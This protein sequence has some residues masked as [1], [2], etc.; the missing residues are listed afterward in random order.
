M[1]NFNRIQS[2][3]S[4][5][6]GPSQGRAGRIASSVSNVPGLGRVSKESKATLELLSDLTQKGVTG[7]NASEMLDA[8]KGLAKGGNKKAATVVNIFD[9][10]AN[11][12]KTKP[13]L[14]A[15]AVQVAQNK[16]AN[17]KAA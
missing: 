17:L 1:N 13:D 12:A 6:S 8:F 3:V 10:I 5:A 2:V 7:E 15:I 16:L 9:D 4:A 14:D 11:I